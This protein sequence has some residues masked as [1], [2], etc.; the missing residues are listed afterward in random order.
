MKDDIVF[1]LKAELRKMTKGD[2]LR[3]VSNQKEKNA[4]WE[5][6]VLFF[7]STDAFFFAS[8]KS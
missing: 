5:G 1:E 6:Y 8:R 3:M 2:L 7:W 4:C